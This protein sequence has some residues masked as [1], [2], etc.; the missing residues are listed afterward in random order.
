LRHKQTKK[1]QTALKTEPY[2]HAD[3]K[4]KIKPVDLHSTLYMTLISKVLRSN[5]VPPTHLIHN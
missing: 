3:T 2:L 1:S 5:Q 4:S